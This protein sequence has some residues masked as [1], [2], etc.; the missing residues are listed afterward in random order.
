M[1]QSLRLQPRR[2]SVSAM[3]SAARDQRQTYQLHRARLHA[4]K[5]GSRRGDSPLYCLYPT[6]GS[7]GA[8]SKFHA[9]A[10]AVAVSTIRWGEWCA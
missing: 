7:S 5:K 3:P 4:K 8:G 1:S 2:V 6:A 10:A 9:R